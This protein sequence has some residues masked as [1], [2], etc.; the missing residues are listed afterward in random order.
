MP[1]LSL[2]IPDVLWEELSEYAVTKGISSVELMQHSLRFLML[3]KVTEGREGRGMYWHEEGEEPLRISLKS[4]GGDDK[5]DPLD[6]T[7]WKPST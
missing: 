1:N 2:Y 4:M 3:M 7:T 6:P 5:F